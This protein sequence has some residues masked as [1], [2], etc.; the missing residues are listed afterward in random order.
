MISKNNDRDY[1]E[2]SLKNKKNSPGPT[3]Y[4]IPINQMGKRN[5]SIYKTDKKS[6]VDEIQK[7]AKQTPAVGAYQTIK[8]EK[9]KGVFKRYESLTLHSIVRSRNIR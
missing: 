3:S 7:K 5:I 4:N 9:I 6:F 2:K 8:P 1:L